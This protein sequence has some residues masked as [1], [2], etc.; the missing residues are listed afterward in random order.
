MDSFLVSLNS[1]I[2]YMCIRIYK[3]N[4]HIVEIE[5]SNNLAKDEV[6]A[7]SQQQYQ[8]YLSITSKYR[9]TSHS[10]RLPFPND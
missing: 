2:G 5:G 3:R 9:L 8:N 4:N 10:C 1:K 7:C 6:D